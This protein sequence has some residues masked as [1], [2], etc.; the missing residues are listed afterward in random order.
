MGIL[1]LLNMSNGVYGIKRGSDVDI[2]DIEVFMTYAPNRNTRSNKLVKLNASEVILPNMNPNGSNNEI[3]GGLYTLK[4][5]KE[6]FSTRGIYTI[7]I[8]PLEIRTKISDV[9]VLASQPNIR[10]LVFDTTILPDNIKGKFNN[11]QLIGYRVEYLESNNTSNPK[12]RNTFRLITSN[13]RAEPTN[14]NLNNTLQ[15]AVRFVFNDSANMVF[16]TVTP[17]SPNSARP[18]INPFIGE[19]SQDVIL[20]NTFF[21]PIVLEVEMVEYDV[22]DIAIGLFGNQTKSIDDGIWTLYDFDDEIYKQYTLY[23]IKDEY[24]DKPLF[25]V[26]EKNNV[27]DETKSFDNISNIDE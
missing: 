1:I 27:I 15:K 26:R 25:E 24:T 14:M 21:D 11:N 22:E 17:N 23:E 9:G 5:P 19:V 13:N 8:R 16:C 7:V 10:G 18:N 2:S 3:F 12:I 20:T 4:L 6:Y